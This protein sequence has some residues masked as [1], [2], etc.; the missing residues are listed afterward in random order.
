[1]NHTT[2]STVVNIQFPRFMFKLSKY[3]SFDDD[4]LNKL[5]LQ[6]D[7]ID[8][9]I[10]EE[11]KNDIV[12]EFTIHI[13]NLIT[14]IYGDIG[15][16]KEHD[17]IIKLINIYNPN[18]AMTKETLNIL[19]NHV[20]EYLANKNCDPNIVTSATDDIICNKHTYKMITQCVYKWLIA[21]TII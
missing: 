6:M 17:S 14:T 18:I 21:N 4:T 2:P 1:M 9:N 16:I 11:V 19:L 20:Q 8:K 12:K 3:L 7:D 15:F 10:S 5:Y 13:S